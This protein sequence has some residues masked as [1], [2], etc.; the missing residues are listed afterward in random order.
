M[1]RPVGRS[2]GECPH[3]PAAEPHPA[4]PANRFGS[5]RGKRMRSAGVLRHRRLHRP[6]RRPAQIAPDQRGP[7][8]NG[9][10]TPLPRHRVDEA[11]RRASGRSTRSSCP[12]RDGGGGVSSIGRPWIVRATACAPRPAALMT[13]AA[14]SRIASPPPV[15]IVTPSRLPSPEMTGVA[16]AI[17]A[18]CASASPHSASMRA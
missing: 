10:Q 16:N 5:P 6:I 17:A 18:P 14:I 4:S 1:I 8:S 13:F 15:S 12:W 9:R 2:S 11:W 3:R 7:G